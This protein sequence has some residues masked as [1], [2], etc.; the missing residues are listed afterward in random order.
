MERALLVVTSRRM[1]GGAHVYDEGGPLM[2]VHV[3][4]QFVVLL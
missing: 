3:A 1:L 4:Q 2:E